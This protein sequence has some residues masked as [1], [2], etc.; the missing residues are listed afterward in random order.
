MKLLKTLLIVSLLIGNFSQLNAKTLKTSFYSHGKITASGEKF[1][2]KKNT[3][4]S[5]HYKFGTILQLS[6][7][8]KIANVCINDTGGFHKHKRDLDVS[9][10]VAKKLHFTKKGVVNVQSRVVYKP[11]KKTSCNKAIRLYASL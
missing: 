11:K 3:A 5:N 8:G 6:Y 9:Q 4:A 7:K 2:K 1:N 10:G